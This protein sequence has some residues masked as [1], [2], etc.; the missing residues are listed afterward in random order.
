LRDPDDLEDRLGVISFQVEGVPHGKVAAILAFEG[1]IGV[2][3][4]CFC[5]HPY[6]LRLLGVGDE[7]Y[8]AYKSRVLNHDRSTLPGLVRVGLGCY[9]TAEDVD[10]LIAMLKRV[11]V[12]DY[13][14]DYV[15]D[16]ASGMY[17]PRG[18]DP[19]ILNDYFAV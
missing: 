3:S 1:G 15:V 19:A 17:F 11:I 9:N 5:A 6:V 16:R 18:F 2:R 7:E 14:G 8:Q 10:R 13:Q 12:G 4:G